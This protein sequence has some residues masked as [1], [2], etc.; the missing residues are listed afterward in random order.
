MVKILCMYCTHPKILC[1][2][3]QIRVTFRQRREK[4]YTGLFLVGILSLLWNHSIIL[5]KSQI[6]WT[7]KSMATLRGVVWEGGGVERG[8]SRGLMLP[9][10][11][12][13]EAHFDWQSPMHG[14]A[15]DSAQGT[16]PIFLCGHRTHNPTLLQRYQTQYRHG[17]Q[18]DYLC[19]DTE[20]MALKIE[21][22]P[23][24]SYQRTHNSAKVFKMNDTKITIQSSPHSWP[25]WTFRKG[26]HKASLNVI[27]YLWLHSFNVYSVGLLLRATVHNI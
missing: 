10:L 6:R 25:W 16:T 13:S 27:V 3:N 2:S 1:I 5:R 8:R 23:D 17:L 18:M 24:V 7:G 15:C 20:H 14:P 22:I 19:T 12:T 21:I 9:C 11:A 4:G 26:K